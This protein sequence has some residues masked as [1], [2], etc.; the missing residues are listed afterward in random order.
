MVVAGSDEASEGNFVLSSGDAI[1]YQT[2]HP[3]QPNN[4]DGDQHCLGVGRVEDGG[5]HD[6]S[7][8]YRFDF[9]VCEAECKYTNTNTAHRLNKV[10]ATE[11]EPH[12]FGQQILRC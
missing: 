1:P 12:S 9:A 5:L 6:V 10:N 7:C 3:S 4:H 8:D 2:F 11:I